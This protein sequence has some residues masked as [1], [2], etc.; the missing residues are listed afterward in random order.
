MKTLQD[1]Q[2]Q[3]VVAIGRKGYKVLNLESE[4]I[5][6]ARD[7]E[8]KNFSEAKEKQEWREAMQQK[9]NALEIAAARGWPLH[10][11]DFN[12]AFLHGTLYEVIY[13]YAQ[14]GYRVPPGKVCRLKKS[15]YGLKQ[16]S[17]QWNQEFTNKIKAFGSI[18]SSHD[19]RLFV[20]GSA[21][22]ASMFNIHASNIGMQLASSQILERLGGLSS[23]KKVTRGALY[24]LG[25]KSSLME[26]NEGDDNGKIICR[27]RIQKHANPLPLPIGVGIWIGGQ[28]LSWKSLSS[29]HILSVLDKAYEDHASR[30]RHRSP[31]PRYNL[32]MH[33][34]AMIPQVR[35]LIL[36]LSELEILPYRPSVKRLPYDD[37]RELFQRT[38]RL[39]IEG[40]METC[41]K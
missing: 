9:V 37:P 33:V 2:T 7:V 30:H 23:L 17:R 15:L 16:A 39:G 21:Q 28:I 38:S 6:I 13:I 5:H 18:Q 24:I 19:H 34:T 32:R 35:G 36:V 29:L 20:K 26:D 1:L 4:T 27:S 14:E 10:Y 31:Y 11:L 40:P 41:T 8:P 12:N 22:Q 3:R 25:D